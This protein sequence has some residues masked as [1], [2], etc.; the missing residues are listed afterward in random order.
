M[1]SNQYNNELDKLFQEKLT[2]RTPS[3]SKKDMQADWNNIQQQLPNQGSASGGQS[4][5]NSALSGMKGWIMATGAAVIL[6]GG[7]TYYGMNSSTEKANTQKEQEQVQQTSKE[8]PSTSNTSSKPQ[9]SNPDQPSNSAASSSTKPAASPDAPKSGSN[10]QNPQAAEVASG[11]ESNR[12]SKSNNEKPYKSEQATNGTAASDNN[13]TQNLSEESKSASQNTKTG[14]GIENNRNPRA[15]MF[16]KIIF[17]DEQKTTNVF[18]KKPVVILS[19]KTICKGEQL[20]MIP[21]NIPSQTNITYRTNEITKPQQLKEQ[22]SISLNQTGEYQ[23]FFSM[24]HGTESKTTQKTV[25]VHEKPHANFTYEKYGYQKITFE[26]KSKEALDHHWIFGDGSTSQQNNPVH[27]YTSE[28]NYEAKLVV[29]GDE[30]CKDTTE[31]KIT[32]EPLPKPDIRNIFTPNGDGKNDVFKIKIQDPIYYH[33]VIKDEKRN[34]IFETNDHREFWDGTNSRTGKKEE[35]GQ[36]I[37]QLQY[38]YKGQKSPITKQG[39]LNLR[40]KR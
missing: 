13:K 34:E 11:N 40:Y 14:A 32:I 7:I 22:T 17:S 26:P 15:G 25:S 8:H 23:L 20:K 2:N 12:S 37:Y 19:S 5:G 31:K 10:Q 38:K 28:G 21:K 1:K 9:N 27:Y 35:A 33:L 16:P 36:Y 24:D 29:K 3:Y 39:K 18:N 4:T 6:A 30:Q